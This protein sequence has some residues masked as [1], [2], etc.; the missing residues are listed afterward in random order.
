MS[1]HTEARTHG[2]HPFFR[3][4]QEYLSEFVYGGIDGSVTT[5]A[6][7][8]G[9]AGAGLDASV[10]IILGF[11]NLIADGFSMSVGSYLSNKSEKATYRKHQQIEYWEVENIPEK[12]VEEV[13]E[14]YR[15]KG[16]E[17]ELLE[18]VVDVITADKDRWVDVMM[19]EE[20][21]MVPGPKSPLGMAI[22]TFI[23]FVVVGLVPLLVYVADYVNGIGS[24][25]AFLISCLLTSVAFILIGYL[26]AYLTDSS[27]WKGVFETL[28]LGASAAALAYW[29]GHILERWL[30]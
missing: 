10:V 28:L 7:V 4:F 20:L 17:G 9:S 13:R 6:V 12:E 22:A 2:Q 26:K 24:P 11:A 19:K 29:V 15:E 21:E 3:R 5:F 16:F 14:I 30:A 1:I 18:Q 23:A 8:A 27:I 25:N